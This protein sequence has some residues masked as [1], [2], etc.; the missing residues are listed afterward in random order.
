[1]EAPLGDEN[2]PRTIPYVTQILILA[3]I[4]AF[5]PMAYAVFFPE[6]TSA[7]QFVESIYNNFS[8]V[9]ADILGGRNL[10]TLF[11]CMFL[12]ADIFH[13]GGN[14]LYFYI[15]G[16]N[17]EDAF[18]HLPYLV[19]YLVAGLVAGFTYILSVILASG[20]LTIPVLGASG[21]ISGVMGAYGLLF[22]RARIRTFFIFFVVHIPAIIYIGS[23]FV[24]QLL[25][26]VFDMQSSVAYWAHIGGF[27]FGAIIAWIYMSF[28]RKASK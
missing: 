9:P 20:D 12:H 24:L 8:M 23:W 10:Y 21:A 14:M 17:V 11:T 13:I 22:P 4:I 18:G 27:V 28:I 5:I 19:F 3:N 1:V 15:F 7:T 26:T 16:D 2:P 6:N 25:Y